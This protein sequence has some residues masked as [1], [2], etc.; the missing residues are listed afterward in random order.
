[1]ARMSSLLNELSA[2]VPSAASWEALSKATWSER[3]PTATVSSRPANCA[4]VI[5]EIALVLRAATPSL[6]KLKN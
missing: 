3:N 4:V 5:P 2:A 6:C 1:M